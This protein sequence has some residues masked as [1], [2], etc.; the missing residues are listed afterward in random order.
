MT[1]RLHRSINYT[2]NPSKK[3][4]QT[5]FTRNPDEVLEIAVDN[6]RLER[7]DSFKYLGSSVKKDA[8]CV[9]EQ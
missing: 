5:I 6:G 1:C 8:D 7:V 4:L 2:G 3:L 9:S